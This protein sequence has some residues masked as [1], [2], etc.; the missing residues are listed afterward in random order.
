MGAYTLRAGGCVV[1]DFWD[2]S[3]DS[4]VER[5]KH[6]PLASQQVS[7][8]KGGVFLLAN[9]SVGMT[10]IAWLGPGALEVSMLAIP[11]TIAYPLMKRYT[12]YP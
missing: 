11:L 7:L 6:R 2:R 5:T 10:S 4:A 9:F 1:N 12:H 3:I 8:F